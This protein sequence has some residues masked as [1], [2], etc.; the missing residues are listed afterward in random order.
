MRQRPKI[1]LTKN[2]SAAPLADLAQDFEVVIAPD[3]GFDTLRRL[4]ADAHAVVVRDYLPPDLCLH[5]PH[6][7][8]IARHGAG[9][10]LIPVEACSRHGVAVS[11]VPGQNADSVAEYC[12]G[13]ML[14]L[15]RKLHLADRAQ[16]EIGWEAARQLFGNGV[17]LRGRC[18]A[19]IG[20]G[21]IGSRLAHIL[22]LG[23]GMRV[24]IATRNAAAVPAFTA[25]VGV[26][27]AC[28]QADF[29]L[30][31]IPATAETRRMIDA[32]RIAMMKPTAFLIN[33]ARGEI[34]D[35]SA[36]IAALRDKRIA[37]AA[38][39]VLE[40]KSPAADHPLH[41]FDNVLLTPHIAGRSADANLRNGMQ[42]VA[43]LRAIFKGSRPG[44]LVNPEAWPRAMERLGAFRR[45]G[46]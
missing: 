19:V 33:A 45:D 2:L 28:A 16:R 32:R 8:A 22:H 26:D 12:I 41:A 40:A 27:D 6:L 36:L 37:G 46:S 3:I 10:D 34:I 38:L 11:N 14:T 5:A 13:A 25:H 4:A 43:D 30:P 7:I 17:E 9:L 35:E 24:V 21:A 29:L 23:L 44:H 39:D 42:V 18:A 20:C 1:L 31:C 15:A